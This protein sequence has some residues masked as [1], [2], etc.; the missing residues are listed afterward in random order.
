MVKIWRGG[1][2]GTLTQLLKGVKTH[3]MSADGFFELYLFQIQI[4][5]R[6]SFLVGKKSMILCK[7]HRELSFSICSS[8]S[9]VSIYDQ[10]IDI[11]WKKMMQMY[12]IEINNKN[13]SWSSWFSLGSRAVNLL[14]GQKP[15]IILTIL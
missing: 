13:Q 10:L 3:L 11:W 12:Y 14:R 5:F 4:T 7:C 1:T 2:Y 15:F 9:H 8:C 6:L